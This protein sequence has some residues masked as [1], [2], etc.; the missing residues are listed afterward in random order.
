MSRKQHLRSAI[1]GL[2]AFAW[3]AGPSVPLAANALPPGADYAGRPLSEALSDLRSLG[4]PIL[5][6]DAV[7]RP[8]MRVIRNPRSRDPRAALDQIL[9]GH[10]LEVREMPDGQLVIA[11]KRV[12][13]GSLLIAV[14]LPHDYS[15]EIGVAIPD[16]G[17]E[18]RSDASE[19]LIS[20]VPAGDHTILVSVSGFI[21][22]TLEDVPVRESSTTPIAVSM[23]P[24]LHLDQ[25]QVTPGHLELRRLSVSDEQHLS[26]EQIETMPHVGDDLMR[27]VS[28]SPGVV[29]SD[30]SA[31]FNARGGGETETL[32]MLD[33]VEIY[34]PFH[35]KDFLSIF[36]IIDTAAVDEVDLLSGAFT[37]E[38]GDRMS[39]VMDVSIQDA[40]TMANELMIGTLNSRVFSSGRFNGDRGEWLV[41]GRGW[42]PSRLPDSTG[43][44]EGEIVADY[45]DLLARFR[46]P[47]GS[48]T[49]A[50]FGILRAYD[51][52]SFREV[53]GSELEFIAARYRSNQ[54]WIVLDGALED[55]TLWQATASVTDIERERGG[56]ELDLENGHLLV[57]D[58]R[59]FQ[60][61]DFRSDWSWSRHD[62]HLIRW[63]G[64]I[65]NQSALYD[66]SRSFQPSDEATV[67]TAPDIHLQPEGY[68]Y[69]AYFSDRFRFGERAVVELG[70]RWDH[71]DWSED[72]QL[73][74]RANLKVDLTRRTDLRLGWGIFHQSQ[75]LNELP[76]EDGLTQFSGAE[77][78][79]HLVMS[80]VHT[81]PRSWTLQGVLYDKRF[82]RLRPRYENLFS[83]IE[84]FPES[85]SDRILVAPDRAHARGLE[86]VIRNGLASG[87][88]WWL[89]YVLSEAEDVVDGR[90]VPRSWDQ[91][92][93]I[94]AGI[95]FGLPWDIQASLGG[96]WHSGRPTTPVSLAWEE[97]EGE[98]EPVIVQ[99]PRN[100]AR[101]EDYGRIDLRLSRSF[102][103]RH[104]NAVVV[105]Q[106]FNATNRENVCYIEDFEVEGEGETARI[107]PE[108][109]SCS[110]IIPTL[111]VQWQF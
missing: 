29:E 111:S 17:I 64:G 30:F 67:I 40:G 5:F 75:R 88:S 103:L 6:S 110:P 2:V 36:S 87:V 53:D 38:Y 105:L 8:G 10:P 9:E 95:A 93:S 54:S 25:I 19:I 108:T 3:L 56:E 26:S 34:E 79:E 83:Q 21:P 76:V 104:G 4:L 72:S 65:K 77:R 61:T 23:E 52:L 84:L 46:H 1:L 31:R 71:Q 11:P 58:H 96:S 86:L 47:V 85:R 69:H 7:V 99:G 20:N 16:A 100:S 106:A 18:V 33:G 74:P 12:P 68:S 62:R 35:L 82:E 89:G 37:A 91:R 98:L 66:Y 49:T 28:S 60:S 78:A 101:L 41:T 43:L 50:A 51:D 81:L 94:D 44:I 27:A 24:I 107:I 97:Q 48:R 109:Q 15:G 13:Q 59:R 63:G 73:S 92:H 39:A 70:L 32:V 14:D 102:P 45:Y 57:S 80:I 90:E 42:Y 55:T 22:R